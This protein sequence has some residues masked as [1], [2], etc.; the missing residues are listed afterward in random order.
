MKLFVRWLLFVGGAALLAWF[1]ADAGLGEILDHLGRVGWAV[2]LI[3]LPQAAAY[4]LDTVGWH[5][6]FRRTDPPPP[7]GL[8]TR[9]RLVGETVNNV[10]PSAYVGGEP[11]KAWLLVR[12]GHATLAAAASVVVAKTT[13]TVAQVMFIACGAVCA[14]SVLPAGSPHHLAFLITTGIAVVVVVLLLVLQRRGMFM[15]LV[16]WLERLRIRPAA[17]V[18]RRERLRELD[19]QIAGFYVDAKKRF[20]ASVLWHLLGWFAGVLEVLLIGSL[21]GYDIGIPEAVAIES[22]AHVA[23]AIGLFIPGSLGVQESGILLLFEVF[24]LPRS[25]AVSYALL[26]RGREVF[27]VLLGAALLPG[28]RGSGGR[29]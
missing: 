28:A 4:V 17:L 20:L 21:L 2:P 5:F 19:G 25:P 12:H 16:S 11:V 22:F 3:L 26:R 15:T 23:K 14:A 9:V 24:G 29:P 6:A 13:M 8:L 18:R 27:F 1:V 10:V 7:F